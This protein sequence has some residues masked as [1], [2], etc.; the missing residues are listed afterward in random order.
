MKICFNLFP[1]ANKLIAL[2][3]V[4]LMILIYTRSRA[5]DSLQKNG[6]TEISYTQI[7]CEK[8]NLEMKTVLHK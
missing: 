5:E 2:L 1:P 8:Q 4:L 3:V 7:Q 6:E